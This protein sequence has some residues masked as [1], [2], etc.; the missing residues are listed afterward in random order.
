MSN[1]LATVDRDVDKAAA[2]YLRSTV[3]HGQLRFSEFLELLVREVK[4][5]VNQ[6]WG[7]ESRFRLWFKK[8][9][10]KE[11]EERIEKRIDALM[12]AIQNQLSEYITIPVILRP[13]KPKMGLSL[14]PF[15]AVAIRTKTRHGRGL[16]L[17]SAYAELKERLVLT[18]V[19]AGP[20][21]L[22]HFDQNEWVRFEKATPYLEDRVEGFK[23]NVRNEEIA[24]AG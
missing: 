13:A 9:L 10:S 21:V 3:P 11:I 18:L 17:D 23:I 16:T 7:R 20:E 19:K 22:R 1:A 2:K 12:P 15:M 6:E 24:H 5:S 8:S 14:P 4:R